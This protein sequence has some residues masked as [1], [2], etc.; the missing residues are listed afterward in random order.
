[1]AVSLELET[2]NDQL[3]IKVH[4]MLDLSAWILGLNSPKRQSSSR[5]DVCGAQT[6]QGSG[7][8]KPH[9]LHVSR[10]DMAKPKNQKCVS[11]LVSP[12]ICPI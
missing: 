10:W 12:N 8:H 2:I 6:A 9:P 1:M 7:G 4:Q 5:D 3:W 11:D